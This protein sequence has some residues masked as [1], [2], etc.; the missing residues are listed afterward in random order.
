MLALGAINTGNDVIM[1]RKLL[2]TL[3]AKVCR[4]VLALFKYFMATRER[5]NA[6]RDCKAG[7]ARR[8]GNIQAGYGHFAYK[9][10]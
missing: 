6:Q 1:T 9:G 2:D 10:G 7:R 3:P 4:F 8:D 5:K